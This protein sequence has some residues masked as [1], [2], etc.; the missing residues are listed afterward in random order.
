VGDSGV[1]PVGMASEKDV[2]T[3]VHANAATTR[4]NTVLYADANEAAS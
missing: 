2:R 3:Y 4:T 1:G